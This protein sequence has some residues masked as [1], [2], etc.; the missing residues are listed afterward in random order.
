MKKLLRTSMIYMILAICGGVFFREFTKIL[1]FE[2]LTPLRALH[3]HLFVLGMIFFLVALLLERQFHI[4]SQK[5]FGSFYLLYNIGVASTGCLLLVRGVLVVLG[6]PLSSGMTAAISGIA[7]L[8]HIVL[9]IG[10][11]Q[12]FRLLF[13]SIK[14]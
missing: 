6:T 5:G 1:K 14:E 9:T 10:L 7:G 12:F 11:V 4:S 3:T 8:G 13:K 2:G